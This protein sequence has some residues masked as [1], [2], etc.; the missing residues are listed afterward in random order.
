[1]CTINK[2][3]SSNKIANFIN[4]VIPGIEAE[5]AILDLNS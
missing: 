3:V 4:F 1:M 5:K 2:V